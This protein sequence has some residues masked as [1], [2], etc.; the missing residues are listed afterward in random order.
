TNL[1]PAAVTAASL[2]PFDTVVL[3]VASP[4]MACNTGNLSAAAKTAL[5][6]FVGDP[7]V[8]GHKLII[9]D[10]ECPAQNY[11][12]LPYP[13]TTNNPGAQGAAGQLTIVE[14]NSLSSN[15]TSSPY[16]V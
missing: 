13:F 14:E 8:G 2:A 16:Y 6:N 3:N 15:N 7:L 11:S 12:W 4:Q 9:W 1:L 5:V 10:S